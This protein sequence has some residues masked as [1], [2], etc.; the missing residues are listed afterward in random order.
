MYKVTVTVKAVATAGDHRRWGGRRL[1]V[2]HSRWGN[3][4]DSESTTDSIPARY[5]SDSSASYSVEGG[6]VMRAGPGS[7]HVRTAA[8][9]A[10]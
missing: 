6:P 9:S 1:G 5:S 3:R 8:G 4:P 2:G 10:T 7:A